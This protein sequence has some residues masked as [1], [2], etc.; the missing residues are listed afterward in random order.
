MLDP[1]LVTLRRL[2][3]RAAAALLFGA[4]ASAAVGACAAAQ[5]TAGAPATRAPALPERLDDAAYWRL[6]SDISEPGGY[7]RIVDNFT[8]NEMEVGQLATMLREQRVGGDVYIGVGPEQ[9]FTYIAAIRPRMAFVVDIRRQ[10]VVQ[11]LMYKA[12]FEMA[13]DRADFVSLLFGKPRPAGIDDATPIQRI[14]ELYEGVAADS[15]AAA[16]NYARIA[17]RLTRTHGFALS[18]E[19]S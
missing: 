4:W 1:A 13:R 9:N 10:A 17:E 18:A 2:S 8:S 16:A 5:S 6:L 19:E 11:H 7:F 3:T 15:A 12:I 14:W